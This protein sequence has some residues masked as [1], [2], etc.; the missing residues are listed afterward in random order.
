M[1][2]NDKQ[3][4][5]INHK[6]GP[7]LVLAG[8][9]SGKTRVLTERIIK[10]ID[11]GVSPYNILAITFTNKA[12]KEMRSRV[13]LKLGSPTDSI[14]IGTFHSFGY[15]ILRE[16]YIDAGYTSNITIL[17]ADDSKAL[18]KRILKEM[19]L[20]PKEYDI[21]HIITKIS[22]AKNDGLS[23]IEY[24]K[25]FLNDLDKVIGAIY[26]KYLKL[27][28]E[29][30]S[31]D[32]DDL[33]LKP[34]ELFKTNKNILEKYQDR[35]MY[36]LVDEYQDTNSI[37][38]ELC[39][40]LASKYHNL[41]VVGDANQSIYSWRNADYKN[42][43]NFEKDYKDAKVVLLEEN[44]RS[45]NN[46]LQAA[47]SVI[48]NNTEGKKLNLWTSSGDGEKIDYIRCEDE[49]KEAHFVTSKIKDLVNLGYNYNDFA[50]LYR[51]NAQ[52][53]VIEDEFLTSNIPY[54]IIGSYY[55]YS[56]K[57]IKDL[58]AYLNLIY[59]SNDSVSLERVIN[60][61]KRGIGPKT[62]DNLR[63]KAE[64][65]NISLFDAIDSGKEL[66]FK[67]I[68]L[69][70][71]EDSKNMS[72]S[73]LIEDTLVK[74]GLRMEYELDKS[75][76]NEAKI[77]NLNEFKSVAVA[78]EE[79]GI[80]DLP[81]FLE[82]ILLVSDRSQYK[83]NSEAVNL[84]TLHSAKGLEFKVVFI[85][86]MEEGIFPHMRSFESQSELEEER[87]LCYVGITRAKTKLYLLSA[88]NRTLYG[89]TTTSI[90]SRFVKEIEP[91][92]MNSTNTQINNKDNKVIGNMYNESSDD[93]KAGDKVH[94]TAFG[95]GVVVKVSGGIA[96]IA[97][98]Y[99]IGIKS[100]AANHKY[101]TKKN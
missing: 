32:F 96:T 86:G 64:L 1:V 14:F 60:T 53:R 46:I 92:L 33:L 26:E 29:N 95:D 56:R 77:E 52:S 55:F 12:A 57:E 25:L 16:N 78:F 39:K 13:E 87:R 49:I 83:E 93:I 11:D 45:T 84:M 94:H 59:N 51:T 98:N 61:P 68:I 74:T 10:L 41:F 21:K 72:L 81:T 89:K 23:P 82:N 19:E 79:S 75:L 85:L 80:Y 88:R 43:L 76:D 42:I 15:K 35:F 70:L 3:I 48:K 9:G 20:D 18:I 65:N 66:E 40:L 50:V 99:G 73:E 17:D 2:L 71:I 54:N 30:N 44:Y 8:A 4:E 97:F 22:N 28:K 38:Y 63:Q 67:K 69:E 36:I 58:I 62:I 5:A 37:Q 90:E 6:E 91:S 101:L 31:V 7:C 47:N 100:I 34:V 27:L 24:K